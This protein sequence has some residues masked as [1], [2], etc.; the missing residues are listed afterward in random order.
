[1]INI[2]KKSGIS[3]RSNFIYGIHLMLFACFR[4]AKAKRAGE[5]KKEKQKE[6]KVDV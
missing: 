3:N 5:K 6:S 4:R 2:E 1:M